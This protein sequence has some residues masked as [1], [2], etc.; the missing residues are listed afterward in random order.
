[1][2]YW[3]ACHGIY[4]IAWQFE[5]SMIDSRIPKLKF[6]TRVD[7]SCLT[8]QIVQ[9]RSVTAIPR[10]QPFRGIAMRNPRNGAFHGIEVHTSLQ[11]LGTTHSTESNPIFLGMIVNRAKHDASDQSCKGHRLQAAKTAGC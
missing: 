4:F 11:I 6:Q 5:S 7:K 10:N 3:E 2:H 8:P 1:M 9:G